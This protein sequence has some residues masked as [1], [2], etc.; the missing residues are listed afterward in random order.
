MYGAKYIRNSK[1]SGYSTY[2]WALNIQE[3]LIH[4]H[5]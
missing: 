4:Y 3:A 2:S 1:Y 5:L